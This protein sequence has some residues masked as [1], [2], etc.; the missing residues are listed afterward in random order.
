LQS[1]YFRPGQLFR[2]VVIHGRSFAGTRR[3]SRC[4]YPLA[5]GCIKPQPPANAGRPPGS[6]RRLRKIKKIADSR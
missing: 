3:W 5:W 2:F 6:S 1:F 4:L